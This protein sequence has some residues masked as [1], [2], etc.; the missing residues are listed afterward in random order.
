MT[1][2]PPAPAACLSHCVSRDSHRP[3]HGN[4]LCLTARLSLKS[5]GAARIRGL[6]VKNSGIAIVFRSSG[7]APVPLISH[8]LPCNVCR[9]R[10]PPGSFRASPD[11]IRIFLNTAPANTGTNQLAMKI[12]MP[13]AAQTAEQNTYET[14]HISW[15]IIIHSRNTTG[16]K[17][18]L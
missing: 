12:V 6:T 9:S 3:G 7:E 4:P 11:I 10:N 5:D 14:V 1:Q 16:V 2:S 8:S 18:S 17:T 15:D 13:D